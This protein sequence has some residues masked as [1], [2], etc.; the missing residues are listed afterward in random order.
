MQLQTHALEVR[1]PGRTLCSELN[2]RI[3]DGEN[4]AVLGANGS[5][6]TTLL[7]T[8][9]G[10]RAPD[11][12]SVTLGERNIGEYSHR[13]RA[14]YVGVL[15]QDYGDAFP[16]TVIETVLSGRHPYLSRWRWQDDADDLRL[17][18]QALA[19]VGLQHFAD[20]SLITLSG[21]ERRR[22]EIATL[23][24][25]D[26]PIRLLDEPINH[27]DLRHQIEML[28]LLTAGCRRADGFN[29]I[30]LHDVNMA[31]RFC[32]HALLMFGNGE[33]LYGRLAD[34]LQTATLE[35]LYGCPIRR[36]EADGKSFYTPV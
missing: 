1:V 31:A 29:M 23:L 16:S 5:G 2:L 22:A 20:R 36:I 30:V 33:C 24:A 8:L 13:A 17:A 21:G 35:R 10:L 25:Q 32:T 18:Q 9:A 6:K 15:L 28:Q 11:A 3:N 12:G 7:H 19:L 34:V 14:R 26:P 4:W 27:L